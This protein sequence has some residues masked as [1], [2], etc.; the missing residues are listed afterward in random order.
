MAE[1]LALFFDIGLIVILLICIYIGRKRGFVK[2]VIMLLG[3]IIAF[4]GAFFISKAV[5]PA[6]YDNFLKS[7]TESFV[8]K[9]MDKIDIK[10]QIK[11][12]IKQQNVGVEI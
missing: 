5:S 8:E 2:S 12:M 9:N 1:N 4:A 10:G 6:I 3:Y 7:K 11:E